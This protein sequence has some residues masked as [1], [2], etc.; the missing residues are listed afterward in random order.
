MTRI[1]MRLRGFFVFGLVLAF[2][3]SL[4][5]AE[6]EVEEAKV[7]LPTYPPLALSGSSVWSGADTRAAGISWPH[8]FG[9][10]RAGTL[11]AKTA[12]RF[13]LPRDV[14]GT[15]DLTDNRLKVAK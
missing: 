8:E 4:C 9:L 3:P 11:K 2:A 1:A 14:K 12:L 6:V 7:T 10:S 5:A 15:F 13:G